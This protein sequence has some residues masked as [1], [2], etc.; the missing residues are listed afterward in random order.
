MNTEY[1]ICYFALH[2]IDQLCWKISPPSLDTKN[3]RHT[4]LCFLLFYNDPP[5]VLV[6]TVLITRKVSSH[7]IMSYISTVTALPHWSDSWSKRKRPQ[8]HL[9]TYLY[10]HYTRNCICTSTTT[11]V[12]RVHHLLLLRFAVVHIA[13]STSISFSF[14]C[15][16][17]SLTHSPSS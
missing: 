4:C 1:S 3:N 2:M 8:R 14:A 16:D 10:Y 5:F 6:A 9:S 12:H 11:P 17:S 15:S 13:F 7:R